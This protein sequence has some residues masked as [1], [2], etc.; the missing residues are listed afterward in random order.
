MVLPS[1]TV[2]IA[3]NSIVI[4]HIT[5]CDSPL[6]RR[7]SPIETASAPIAIVSP[8]QNTMPSVP[9]ENRRQAFSA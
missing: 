9:I 1:A 6:R 5:Q 8:S 4:S 7:T 2:P 3:S